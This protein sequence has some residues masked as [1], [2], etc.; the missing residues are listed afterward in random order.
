MTDDQ[1]AGRISIR[2]GTSHDLDAVIELWKELMD[3]HAA[4][5][6]L[7]MMCPEGPD[8]FRKHL[9]ES[10]ESGDAVVFVAVSD[11]RTVGYLKAEIACYPPVFV[12]KRYGAISDVAV[13]A[14]HRRMGT[15]EMLVAKALDWFRDRGLDRAEMRLSNFNPV[16]RAFWEKIGFQPYVTTLF[17]DL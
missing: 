9:L 13:T 3:F 15:G 17:R 1:L 4:L 10:L 11:N 2:T 12:R 6:P 16:S 14:D 8:N 5:D 7:F